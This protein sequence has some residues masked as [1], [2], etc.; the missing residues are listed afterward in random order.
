MLVVDPEKKDKLRNVVAAYEYKE[1]PFNFENRSAI[2]PTY[3]R[4]ANL[5]ANTDDIF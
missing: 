4:R 1:V 3:E 2:K 5:I